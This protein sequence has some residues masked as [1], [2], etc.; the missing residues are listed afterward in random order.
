MALLLAFF[1]TSAPNPSLT[2]GNVV[3]VQSI[4]PKGLDVSATRFGGRNGFLVQFVGEKVIKFIG[5]DGREIKSYDPAQIPAAF[6]NPKKYIV[7]YASDGSSVFILTTD[8]IEHEDDNLNFYISRFDST[9][10]YRNSVKLDRQMY[11]CSKL[12]MLSD[13]RLIVNC[14][15]RKLTEERTRAVLSPLTAVFQTNGQF[16]QELKLPND[17]KQ[18]GESETRKDE[19]DL[20]SPMQAQLILDSSILDRDE[21]GDVLISRFLPLP[22]STSSPVLYTISKYGEVK[23]IKLQK[24]IGK[25][26]GA[27]TARLFDGKIALIYGSRNDASD[28]S[29]CVLQIY[30]LGGKLQSS[31]HYD[32]FDFG[33]VLLNINDRRAVFAI[34]RGDPSNQRLGLIEGL[35]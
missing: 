31:Y 21:Y 9:G 33:V 3:E 29:K 28:R 11:S 18:V 27:L 13:D 16:L 32:P 34:Q 2:R 12:V 19:L 24:S 20:P 14:I 22:E 15:A 17:V 10:S 23:R 6:T 30:D 5:F 8:G 25:Y 4:S 35:W 26:W 7:D 1:G